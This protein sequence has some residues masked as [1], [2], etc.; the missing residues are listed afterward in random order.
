MYII[1]WSQKVSASTLG[2][3][4]TPRIV[5]APAAL[6]VLWS[7]V[8]PTLPEGTQRKV[9]FLPAEKALEFLD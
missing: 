8:K 9:V 7:L 6:S 2:F 3:N 1:Y 5:D 4:I